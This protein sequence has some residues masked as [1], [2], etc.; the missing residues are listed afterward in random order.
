MDNGQ[1]RG[2]VT[3]DLM[4]GEVKAFQCKSVILACE[5]YQ[6]L[7][8]C[9]RRLRK[10]NRIGNQSR[11]RAPTNNRHS[12]PPYGDQGYVNTYTVR[13]TFS[14]GRYR[15]ESGDDIDPLANEGDAVIDLRFIEKE[16]LPWLESMES[17]IGPN[18]IEYQRR[19][20]SCD[21]WSGPDNRGT[22]RQRVGQGHDGGWE[23]VG[24]RGIRSPDR[25]LAQA[26][27]VPK[28]CLGTF[29]LRIFQQ[30]L[31]LEMRQEHGPKTANLVVQD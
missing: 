11:D 25:L 1:V 8:T 30:G 12:I 21:T 7:W 5:G 23:D 16:E 31:Q 29:Y 27:T 14:R 22:S 24:H 10:C 26:F 17:D 18:W 4:D 2:L 3:P 9:I 28:F 13:G 15:S 20:C 6:G 19:C